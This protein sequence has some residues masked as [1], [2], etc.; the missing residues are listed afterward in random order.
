MFIPMLLMSG[1]KQAYDFIPDSA[2]DNKTALIRVL[3]SY[4]QDPDLISIMQPSFLSGIW[5]GIYHM[6]VLEHIPMPRY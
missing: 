3:D 5:G 6:N 4:R 1:C 2:G